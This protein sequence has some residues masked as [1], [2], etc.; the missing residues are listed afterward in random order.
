MGVGKG[1][2]CAGARRMLGGGYL[3]CL[4]AAVGCAEASHAA[5]SPWHAASV[6][7]LLSCSFVSSGAQLWDWFRQRDAQGVG[8]GVS[9]VIHGGR[10]CRLS[11]TRAGAEP[12]RFRCTVRQ[13][14]LGSVIW[15]ALLVWLGASN[16][17][18]ANDGRASMEQISICGWYS[19]TA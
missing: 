6:P 2:G 5:V 10:S 16:Q 3:A 7:W 19:R 9:G 11:D 8:G 12:V 1:C 14:Q 18:R 13:L 15:C 17:Q 4:C